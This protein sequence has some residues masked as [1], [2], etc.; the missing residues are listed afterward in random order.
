MTIFQMS[1]DEF[2]VWSAPF[3]MAPG[4][5]E[6][7]VNLESEDSSNGADPFLFSRAKKKKKIGEKKKI[8][9]PNAPPRIVPS[10]TSTLGLATKATKITE[11]N[12]V[13]AGFRVRQIETEKSPGH[14]PIADTEDGQVCFPFIHHKYIQIG[15]ISI[16]I[17]HMNMELL[18]CSDCC[19]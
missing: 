5:V 10:F 12:F 17:E 8:K 4:M 1:S 6:E 2:S 7:T 19:F 3:I 15:L 18:N 11:L 9:K 14:G 16:I 13:P